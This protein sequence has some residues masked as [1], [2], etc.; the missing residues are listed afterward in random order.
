MLLLLHQNEDAAP[1]DAVQE[2]QSTKLLKGSNQQ[3]VFF[4]VWSVCKIHKH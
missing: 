1:V 2:Y 4:I 3:D